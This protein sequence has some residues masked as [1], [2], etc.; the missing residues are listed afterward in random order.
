MDFLHGPPLN[1][2]STLHIP[3]AAEKEREMMAAF[4]VDNGNSV[5]STGPNGHVAGYPHAFHPPM[6]P[7]A[8]YGGNLSHL[9]ASRQMSPQ[10][11]QVPV[12][13]IM[14]SCRT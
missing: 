13:R 8:T 6:L 2:N 5:G 10:T 9:M 11:V 3:T 1:P 7:F 12:L 14:S 4:L